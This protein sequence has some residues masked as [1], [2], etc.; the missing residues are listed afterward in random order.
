MPRARQRAGERGPLGGRR[1]HPGRVVRRVDDDEPGRRVSVAEQPRHVERPAVRL[2][3]LVERDVGAGRAGHLVEALV[4]GPR[5][6][7]RD[8]PARAA[9]LTRQKIASS[10]PA[11]SRTSS[12]SMASYRRGDLAP[13]QRVAGRF[14]VAERQAVPQRS[15]LVVGQREELAPSARPGRPTRTGGARPRTPSE[16]SS[17]RARSRRCASVHDAARCP[18]C[19]S[20]IAIVGIP[21]ALGGHLAGMELAP[22]GLRAAGLVDR[23]ARSTGTPDH[24]PV[25][26]RQP[27]YRAR[28]PAGC[29]PAREE[30]GRD[31]RVPAAGARPRRDRPRRADRSIA[32]RPPPDPGRRLHGPRGRAGRASTA[33][34][35]RRVSRSPGSMRMGTSTR[36]TRRRQATSGACR[37]R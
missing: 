24:G 19:T 20:P 32:S 5:S 23:P 25:R 31:R 9:T 29:R 14:R 27:R 1:Q 36:P 3:Q 7:S 37:S 34:G 4:A 8:R 2:V 18:P 22:S 35:P 12:G 26:R 13:Q 6:R 30:P 28:I 17:A 10:A 11:K 16:R 15:R 21:T 33:S